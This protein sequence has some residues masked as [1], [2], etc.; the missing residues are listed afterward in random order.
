MLAGQIGH[1]QSEHV[2]GKRILTLVT[3]SISWFHTSSFQEVSSF[4]V[5]EFVTPT[6]SNAIFIFDY[7]FTST[8]ILL[9]LCILLQHK[10]KLLIFIKLK[11]TTK[12]TIYTFIYLFIYIFIYNHCTPILEPKQEPIYCPP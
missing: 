9:A 1:T 3:I 5:E 11:N 7:E 12:T 4:I 2:T 10:K 6:S 8:S